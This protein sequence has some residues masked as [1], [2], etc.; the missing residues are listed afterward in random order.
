MAGKEGRLERQ[1]SSRAA[2]AAQKDDGEDVK[3]EA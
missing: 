1:V 2:A 3:R